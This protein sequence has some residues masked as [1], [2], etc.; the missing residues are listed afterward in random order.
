MHFFGFGSENYV[1]DKAKHVIALR[2]M[3][4]VVRI[5]KRANI[6]NKQSIHTAS[7]K[8]VLSF[9]TLRYCLYHIM[10]Y[11]HETDSFQFWGNTICESNR[12]CLVLS[13]NW[14]N[15]HSHRNLSCSFLYGCKNSFVQTCNTNI[16]EIVS[17]P[18]QKKEARSGRTN[19]FNRTQQAMF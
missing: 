17:G 19:S 16:A 1:V 10:K 4:L 6:R 18:V 15:S 9:S 5:I 12:T 11:A 14:Q 13:N 8:F 3:L 7:V 2:H